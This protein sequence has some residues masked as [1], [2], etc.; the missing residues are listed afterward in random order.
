PGQLRPEER[1]R[2]VQPPEVG[3]D[4]APVPELGQ[5]QPLALRDDP[6]RLGGSLLAGL[7]VARERVLGL[8]EGLED[9]PLVVVEGL[10]LLRLRDL[11][12][13]LVLPGVEDR[14]QKV[15]DDVPGLAR[16]LEERVDVRAREAKG[17]S[18]GDA[19]EEER[20][21]LA[22]V[23]GGGGEALLGLPDVG[24]PLEESGG[25]AGRDRVRNPLLRDGEAA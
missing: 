24:T 3:S 11:H 17:A 18:E 10:P 21:R 5:L 12:P 15:A 25:K 1:A 14:L 22:D 8:A 4:A 9:R 13:P 16:P 7:A 20:L 23:R 6:A 2:R 19:R